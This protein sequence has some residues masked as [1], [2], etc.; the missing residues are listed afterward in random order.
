MDFQKQKN[1]NR[2]LKGQHKSSVKFLPAINSV[3]LQFGKVPPQAKELE[4]AVLG[5]MMLDQNA[6]DVAVEILND[7]AFYLE[8]HQCIFRACI[9]LLNNNLPVDILTVVEALKATGELDQVGGPWAVTRLTNI[10]TSSANIEAHA[11]ILVQKFIQREMIRISGET[12][13]LAYEDFTDAFDLMDN[14]ENQLLQLTQGYVKNDFKDSEYLAVKAMEKLD[15]L[16]NHTEELSGVPTGFPFLNRKTNGWQST[17]LI[18]LA[19]RP[20]V[21]KT[22]FALNLAINAANDR[23]KPTPVAFFSLEMSSGQL[24]NRILSSESQVSLEK[25]SRGRMD[26]TEYDK[27]FEANIR[28]GRMSIYIDDTASLNILEFRS[29]ARRLVSKH[30][31]G[32]II[33]DYLQLMG[34]TGNGNREQEVSNISRNLKILAKQLKIPIIALSQM[35]RGIETRK[36]KPEPVLSDLRES[37]AI[38]QDADMVMFLYRPDYQ[39]ASDEGDFTVK[40]DAFIKIAKHRNGDLIKIPF[41]TDL[42]IQKWF[43]VDQFEKYSNNSNQFPSSGGS[44]KPVHEVIPVRK[45]TP[46]TPPAIEDSEELP[47]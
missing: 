34:G 36:D 31:V 18:I 30:G 28:F 6:L 12:I 37:G 4:E 44:W 26:E 35:S 24:V 42:S 7:K 40:G 23:L 1:T 39:Q 15:F 19:A 20:S 5:A 22:A 10:A 17:D 32:L 41:K 45:D 14:H 9:N 47:F 16:R 43:D 33:I 46:F 25:I 27:V 38:E 8:G 21:G 2:N 11:R 29:K 13:G 3:N